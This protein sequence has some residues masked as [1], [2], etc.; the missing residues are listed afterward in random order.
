MD[1]DF[2]NQVLPSS[3]RLFNI[4][5]TYAVYATFEKLVLNSFNSLS[6]KK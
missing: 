2:K 6:K 4:R 1:L 3:A 5:A